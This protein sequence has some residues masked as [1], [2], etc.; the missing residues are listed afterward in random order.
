MT[1]S[2]KRVM[3]VV[4][5]G[6]CTPEGAFHAVP[7]EGVARLA[8]WLRQHGIEVSVVDTLIEGYDNRLIKGKSARYG[9][10]ASQAA[11]R[12]LDWKPDLIGISCLFTCIAPDVMEIAKACKSI[13]PRIPLVIGGAHAATNSVPILEKEQAVDFVALGEGEQT[14]MALIDCLRNGGNP[15]EIEG[16]TGRENGQIFK[17]HLVSQN[18]DLNTLPP[19]AWD[20][21][22]IDSYVEAD[23]PLCGPQGKKRFLPTSWSRGCI[24]A[25]S[26]CL[27]SRV[28]GTGN[29]QKRSVAHILDEVKTLRNSFNIEELHVQ[30][31]CL[32]A[33]KTWLHTIL[34]ALAN[35]HPELVLDFSNGFD[36]MTLDIETIARMAHA[37][38]RRVSLSLE[39]GM[40]EKDLRFIHKRVPLSHAREIIAALHGHAI[41][42]TG[43][44]M[45][46]FPGQTI[47]DM[48]ATVEYALSLDF[49]KLCLFIATPFP[50]SPLYAYCER[51]GYL[52]E[53]H[54]FNDFRFSK[55]L[56]QTGEF[57]P[58]DTERIRR[59]GW[60]RHK[61][62]LFEAD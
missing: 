40:P 34:D 1:S 20:L 53:P 32:L 39:A 9:L 57:G 7:P 8:A 50:G 10:T 24:N 28:W 46:G 19:P 45:M 2:F 11:D 42:I 44:F 37:G 23:S 25:C 38:T 59:D 49:D 41:Y 56:I 3:L 33:D 5:P 26:Y 18:I 35:E 43:N 30:D 51:H 31:D 62:K 21:F 27:T 15:S 6:R 60:L 52:V 36:I 47:D 12:V 22:S 14:F 61:T 55:G 48:E 29:Y 17:G 16:L 54:N 13:E 4:P 58:K